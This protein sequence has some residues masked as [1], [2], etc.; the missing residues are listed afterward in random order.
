MLDALN[1]FGFSRSDIPTLNKTDIKKR[2]RS[3][4]KNTHPDQAGRNEQLEKQ[5]EAITVNITEAYNVLVENLDDVQAKLNELNGASNKKHDTIT[6][7]I[8]QLQRFYRD[9]QLKL[10]DR[11]I[12]SLYNT[13]TIINIEYSYKFG[14]QAVVIGNASLAKTYDNVYEIQLVVNDSST[15]EEREVYVWLKDINKTITTVTKSKTSYMYFDVGHGIKIKFR[16]ERVLS[17]D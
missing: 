5:L 2:Y 14:E 6:L 10:D 9:K 4:L 12:T 16:F 17:N 7:N 3:I 15:A 1:I 13:N 8:E 11:T